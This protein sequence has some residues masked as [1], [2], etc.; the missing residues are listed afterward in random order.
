MLQHETQTGRPR[1]RSCPCVSIPCDL[2]VCVTAA[3]GLEKSCQNRRHAQT[4]EG[5]DLNNHDCTRC[6]N[7]NYTPLGPHS[8]MEQG[9]PPTKARVLHTSMHRTTGDQHRLVRQKLRT[10]IAF[11]REVPPLKLFNAVQ[12]SKG[13]GTRHSRHDQLAFGGNTKW[14]YDQNTHDNTQRSAYF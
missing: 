9:T 1:S 3:A 8:Y 6:S 13:T 5:T 4:N 14:H 11:H 10:S 2:W 12:I 7:S